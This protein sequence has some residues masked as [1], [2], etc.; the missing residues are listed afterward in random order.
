VKLHHQPVRR[1]LEHLWDKLAIISEDSEE[2]NLPVFQIVILGF[3]PR[4]ASAFALAS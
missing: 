2:Y 4:T 1:Q 3:K